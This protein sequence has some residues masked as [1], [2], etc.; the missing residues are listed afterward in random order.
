MTFPDLRQDPRIRDALA[1]LED[2]EVGLD[3]AIVAA[4]QVEREVP[5]TNLSE[6]DIQLIEEHARS[7]DAPREL[8]ELQQRVD[9]EEL[10]WNDIATGRYMNDPEVQAALN[11]G[12]AGLQRAYS[13]IQEGQELDEIISNGLP[14]SPRA[15]NRDKS[16]Q[17]R[18]TQ[19]DDDDE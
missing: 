19:F 12:V 1:R 4:K 5:K 3:Q 9:D 13:A 8:R 17:R 10:S 7:D 14:P 15:H 11:P 18:F 6:E 2:A 16:G